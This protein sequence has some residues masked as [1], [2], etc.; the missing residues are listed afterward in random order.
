VAE[1]R[2]ILALTDVKIVAEEVTIKNYYKK[3]EV[4]FT[5]FAFVA[6]GG[7]KFD[8]A[9]FNQGELCVK[10]INCPDEIDFYVDNKGY[11]IVRG[12][13]ADR[14]SIDGDGD[15]VYL[16]DGYDYVIYMTEIVYYSAEPVWVTI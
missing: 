6:S 8:N 10:M 11:L 15:L 12:T 5:I 9:D 13:N 7:Q 1:K 2:E 4:P 3:D 16:D 14:Y